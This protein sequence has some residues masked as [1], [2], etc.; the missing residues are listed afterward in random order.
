MA[1]CGWFPWI[2]LSFQWRHRW[3][4]HN[5]FSIFSMYGARSATVQTTGSLE[6]FH[7][8]VMRQSVLERCGGP[9]CL[10]TR[11][12]G[13]A[14]RALFNETFGTCYQLNT[15]WHSVITCNYWVIPWYYLVCLHFK[16]DEPESRDS[17]SIKSWQEYMR[18]CPSIFRFGSGDS[19][20]ADGFG[21]TLLVKV[22]HPLTF[23]LR[24]RGPFKFPRVYM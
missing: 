9:T 14:R 21:S 5:S 10:Q 6:A 4:N 3:G 13:G 17:K 23:H 1:V 12:L 18:R 2:V 24:Q 20:G 11:G 22:R 7:C 16:L 8:S 15:T 19:A